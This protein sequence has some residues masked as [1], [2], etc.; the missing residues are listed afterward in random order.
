MKTNKNSNTWGWYQLNVMVAKI[1]LDHASTRTLSKKH[2]A[3]FNS[4]MT[5]GFP[6]SSVAK[7]LSVKQEMQV[8]SLG[9]EDSLEEKMATHSS[10][11]A[12]EIP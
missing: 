12:R 2:Y 5:L 7:N 6:G 11:L 4:K 10:V 8:Q 1:K 3:L 9:Q